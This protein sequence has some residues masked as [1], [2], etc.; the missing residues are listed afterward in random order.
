MQ[1]R[2]CD[3]H[4][5]DAY[6]VHEDDGEVTHIDLTLRRAGPAGRAR[7]GVRGLPRGAAPAHGARRQ[8]LF[9]VG[10]VHRDRE[11]RA[12][13]PCPASP[14]GATSSRRRGPAPRP[15]HTRSTRLREAVSSKNVNRRSPCLRVLRT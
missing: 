12:T 2:P 15:I 7:A 11:R 10:D 5:D 6:V 1:V 3:A 4:F 14:S 13:T 8:L 9:T